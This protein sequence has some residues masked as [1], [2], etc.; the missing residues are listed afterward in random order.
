MRVALIV[1]LLST[2]AFGQWISYQAP[3]N[4]VCFF[5]NPNFRGER[6]CVSANE[7][8]DRVPSTFRRRISSLR[9]YGNAE[10]EVFDG[11]NLNGKALPI[12]THVRDL[13]SPQELDFKGKYWN[14]RIASFRVIDN[15]NHV[16]AQGSGRWASRPAVGAC[17]FREPG[18]RGEFFCFEVGR[19]EVPRNF[20]HDIESI[21]VQ[22]D[23]QVVGYDRG[24]F[25]GARI[26]I[27]SNTR[28]L[29]EFIREDERHRNWANRIESIEI[30]PRENNVEK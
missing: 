1:V 18:F 23:V 15:P 5:T 8:M 13:R 6:F 30:R 12:N 22:G 9:L 28:D 10:L 27:W 7:R 17:F 20:R 19:Q 4:G 3:P 16:K 11:E 2:A 25:T 26:H 21:T 29:H 24:D 14:D